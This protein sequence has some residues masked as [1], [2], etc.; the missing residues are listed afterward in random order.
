MQIIFPVLVGSMRIAG[1]CLLLGGLLLCISIVWAAVGFLMMG[2][3]L[4]C[5]LIAERRKKQSTAPPGPLSDAFDRRREPPPLQIEKHAQSAKSEEASPSRTEPQQAPSSLP[6]PRQPRP[7]KPTRILREEQPD[8]RRS[9]PDTIPYDL[10]KW[11]ALV[12]TDA[13]ISRSV[14]ALQPFGK[15]YVDQLAMAY[16]AFEEKSYLPVIVKLVAHA[17]K[18][19]SGRDS[20]STAAM[21]GD[22]NTDLISVAISKAR[23]SVVGQALASPALNDGFTEKSSSEVPPETEPAARMKLAAVQSELKTSRILPQGGAGNTKRQHDAK[24]VDEGPAVSI[25]APARKATVSIDD[26]RDLT[27]LL[28][29]IA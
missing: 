22:P 27:D 4:I 26:A 6:E 2:F 13:D 21:D 20:A 14:E 24:G 3:G 23:T 15:K 16:L 19:G 17:I 25:L 7:P 11:R 28:N 12:K 18:R 9:V 10:E 8:G 29:R 1:A 5:L